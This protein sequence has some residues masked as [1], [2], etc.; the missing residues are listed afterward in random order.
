VEGDRAAADDL[1]ELPE[2][3]A[4]A[5]RLPDLRRLQQA[6]GHHAFLT[7]RYGAVAWLMEHLAEGRG[8]GARLE[9]ALREGKGW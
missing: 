5:H 6:S 3:E 9:G 7:C 1:P 2:P 4:S 8:H